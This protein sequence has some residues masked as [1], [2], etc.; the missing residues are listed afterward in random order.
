MSQDLRGI[1]KTQWK[2][3]ETDSGPLGPTSQRGLDKKFLNNF[4]QRLT[5]T[6]N[7]FAPAMAPD[8]LL[9]AMSRE[10]ARYNCN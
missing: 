9:L 8:S 4:E 10:S 2:V 3:L 5:H 1:S 6:V 7:C